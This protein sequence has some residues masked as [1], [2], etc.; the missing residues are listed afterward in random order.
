MLY[1]LDTANIED[2]Q[3]WRWLIDGITTN[4]SIMAQYQPSHQQHIEQ[5]CQIVAPMPVSVEVTTNAYQDMISQGHDILSICNN[6]VLKL[7]C[8]LQ[9]FKACK[10]FAENGH[11]VNMTLCFSVNQAMIAAKCGARYVSPFIGRLDDAGYSGIALIYD[12][13]RAYAAQRHQATTILASSVRNVAHVY[14][15]A[16]NGAG[17]ATM[18]ASILQQ[19]IDHPMTIEGVNR[20]LNAWQIH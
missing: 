1:F 19:M 8:N 9:G 16:T 11:L 4:P 15:A 10:H 18:S 12:I 2:I 17:A 5:I 6:V 3:T 7:P 20:F 13:A 14:Q